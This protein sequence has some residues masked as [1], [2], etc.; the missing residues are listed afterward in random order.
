[1]K[2]N[3]AFTLIND[4]KVSFC[5]YHQQF[6]P[7]DHMFRKNRNDFFVGKVENGVVPLFLSSE[8]LYNVVS[9]YGDIMFGFN[10]VSRSF[11]VLV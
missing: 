3:K 2:N 11:L 5:Y 6:L 9:G 1:M 10:P 4:D 8:E 7:T